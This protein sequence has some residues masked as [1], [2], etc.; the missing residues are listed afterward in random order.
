M[1]KFDKVRLAQN[2]ADDLDREIARVRQL[3]ADNPDTNV[4]ARLSYLARLEATKA[5]SVKG[6]G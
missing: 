5:R 3:I 2:S 4:W 6:K 1:R